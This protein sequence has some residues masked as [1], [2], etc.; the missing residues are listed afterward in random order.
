MCEYTPT[1]EAKRANAFRKFRSIHVHVENIDTKEQWEF[2]SI[3][4]FCKKSK[5]I[6]DGKNVSKSMF[7]KRFDKT[8][9]DFIIIDTGKHKFLIKKIRR[10]G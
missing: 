2:N 3:I 5:E 9:E 6:I 7:E 10:N 4:D 8:E 1:E